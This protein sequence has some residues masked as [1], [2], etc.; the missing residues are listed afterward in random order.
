MIRELLRRANQDN[1]PRINRGTRYDNQRV[2][3]VAGAREN[4]GTLIVQKSRIQCYNCKEYGHVSR[5]CQT[6]KRVKDAAYHKEKMLLCKQ[7]EARVQLNADQAD[8]K[9]DT[10]DESDDHE[11]ESHY[12]YMAQIQEVTPDSVDNS[13]PIFDDEP[14]H[15]SSGM[16][17][18]LM[19]L[20]KNVI[21]GALCTSSQAKEAQI[22]FYKTHED[23]ELDK[24]IALENKVKVLDDIVYKTGQ[25]VQI[26]NM[27]NRNYK[28]SFVKREFLKKAQRANPRLYDI[29]CYNDNLALMLAP[30]SDET[31]RLDKESRSKLSDLISPFDYD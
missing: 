19:I 22:K 10:D 7:E 26:M 1:S 23:K 16:T 2:V 18:D 6:P 20:I 15:K 25:S 21:C 14:M 29:G 13:G 27:L 30:E 3:N 9:D 24:V 17:C 28:T 5:E 8:W 12:I 31:I 4:V 11:L